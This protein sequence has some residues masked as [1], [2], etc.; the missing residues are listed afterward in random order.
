MRLTLSSDFRVLLAAVFVLSMCAPP[1]AQEAKID[2]LA[3][4]MAASLSNGTLKTVTVFDFVGPD[5]AAAVG[6]RLAADFRAA[7]AK[8][9]NGIQVEDRS[10]LLDLLRKDKLAPDGISDAGTA[11]WV[12][13]PTQTQAFIL[14]TLSNGSDGL[15]LSVEAF[16]VER[17]QRIS[18]FETSLPL[19]D[20]LKAFIE[21]NK[22]RKDVFGSLPRASTKGHSSPSCI[23]CPQA[24]YSAEAS[25]A[26]FQGNVVLEIT[27]DE[28]GHARDIR[29][30]RG[31]PLGL[32]GQAIEAVQ[33]WRFKPAVDP[34]GNPV[35][36]RTAVEMT[37]HL[38]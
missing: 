24:R 22:K 34:D 36:V 37:F 28:D 6:Q 17:S 3:D 8:S 32:T 18:K 20:D 31:L 19:T 5:E 9:A 4:Q 10:Q 23:Y 7:L 25:R 21:E 30:K 13:K 11:S 35:A 2:A 26:K 27:V 38:Y 33:E 14:G 12:L 29:V 16:R 15:Q 1:P